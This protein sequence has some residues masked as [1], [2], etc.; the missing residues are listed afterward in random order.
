MLKAGPA[1]YSESP[2][3]RRTKRGRGGPR[4]S[5][6]RAP[7]AQPHRAATG[8]PSV[9]LVGLSKVNKHFELIILKGCNPD[10][11]IIFQGEREVVI[12]NDPQEVSPP[13][14]EA[15]VLE[16]DHFERFVQL[17][18]LS[19]PKTGLNRIDGHL[20]V[21]ICVRRFELLL[22]DRLAAIQIECFHHQL[23]HHQLFCGC[24]RKGKRRKAG[25]GRQAHDR[26]E[27]LHIAAIP[28]TAGEK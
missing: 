24:L 9:L 12:L 4:G 2:A 16:V 27:W 20:P 26:K 5:R 22:T 28:T 19:P 13:V 25:D 11:V 3:F 17:H 7:A 15:P 10:E 23:F 14:L 21:I 1:G 8:G 6:E 18:G